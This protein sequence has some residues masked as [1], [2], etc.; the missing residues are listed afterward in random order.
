VI[1]VRRKGYKKRIFYKEHPDSYCYIIGKGPT[2]IGIFRDIEYYKQLLDLGCVLVP[3]DFNLSI[4]SK[5]SNYYLPVTISGTIGLERALAGYHTIVAGYPWYRKE[6]PGILDLNSIK[7]LK[8]IEKSWV[9]HS[10]IKAKEAY[11]FILKNLNNKTLCNAAGIGDSPVD[12][13]A[14]EIYLKEL[15]R[16]INLT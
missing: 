15:R 1:E 6:L 2:C 14:I 3:R 12:K 8:K 11:Q 5:Y 16:L 13:M 10:K 4:N 9:R 7:S